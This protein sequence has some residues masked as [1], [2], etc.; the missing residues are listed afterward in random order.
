[1]SDIC[2]KPIDLR[3]SL[4]QIEYGDFSRPKTLA[5]MPIVLRRAAISWLTRATAPPCSSRSTSSRRM[6][7]SRAT[8]LVCEKD[9]SS[10]LGA[11]P[12][13]ADVAGQRRVDVARLAGDP[14]ALGLA[15]DE[16]QRPHVVQTVGQLHQ[17]DA[18]VLG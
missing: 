10:K 12:V 16:V 9:S 1:M 6:M 17:Q 11:D 15:L 2:E 18:D 14:L 13:A 4:R 3:C 5:G 8:G 7:A